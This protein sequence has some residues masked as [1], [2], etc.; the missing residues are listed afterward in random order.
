MGGKLAMSLYQPLW[1][2]LKC[3]E[4]LCAAAKKRTPKRLI[5][6]HAK[7]M[8]SDRR[9]LDASTLPLHEALFAATA[10]GAITRAPR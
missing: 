10:A 4:L 3:P 5:K 7:K 6:A 1:C 9:H 8:V 2:S